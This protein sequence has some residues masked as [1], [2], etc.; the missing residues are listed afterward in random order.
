MT[1]KAMPRI[2]GS[3]FVRIVGPPV[4]S[5]RGNLWKNVPL[6]VFLRCENCARGFFRISGE[7]RKNAVS[8]GKE[9]AKRK[10]EENEKDGSVRAPWGK[11]L[12]FG[13]TLLYLKNMLALC[14]LHERFAFF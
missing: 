8:R 4:C 11:E 2:G 7:H 12:P 3:C 1:A 6:K 5:H 10:G 9:A 14:S 13:L